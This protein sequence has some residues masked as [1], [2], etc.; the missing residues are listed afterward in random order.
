MRIIV[1]VVALLLTTSLAQQSNDDLQRHWAYDAKAPLEIKQN[2]VERR[3]DVQIQDLSYAT[4]V[5][6]RSASLGPNAGR[7]TAYLVIPKGKGPFPAVI[8]GHWCM[9]GSEQMNRTEFLEEAVVL[10]RSG[11]MSLLPNHVIATQ[12][13]HADEAPLNTQQIDVLVQQIINTRRGADILLAR[14]DVDPARLAYVGHS[15]NGSVAGFLGGI[16]KRFKALVVM[17]GNLSD[18]EDMKSSDYQK[19]RKQVGP[20]KFD[21]FVATYD[22]TDPGKYISHSDGIP[23]LLQFATDEPYL[24][25]DHARRYLPHVSEPKVVHFY[26]APHALNAEATRD[27]INFLSGELKFPKPTDQLIGSI[28]LLKQPPWPKPP[29]AQSQNDKNL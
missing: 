20:E 28:P 19:Y 7:V 25:P 22:W 6:N 26:D 5:A 1:C 14:K 23:K 16:D 13:F 27:R 4:E 10:A 18:V 12:G 17:A 2:G 15:C 24:K 9:R 3:G 11:V 21:A 8:Y 29:Q